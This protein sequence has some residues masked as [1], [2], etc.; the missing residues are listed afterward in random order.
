MT[1]LKLMV[2]GVLIFTAP[3][4]QPV[5]AA[6]VILNDAF[7]DPGN[8]LGINTNGIGDGFTVFIAGNTGPTGLSEGSEWSGSVFQRC[9]WRLPGKYRLQRL[10]TP[11]PQ[12]GPH[13]DSMERTALYQSTS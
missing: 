10:H 3:L 11:E 4:R 12:L 2:C 8:N 5:R 7:N 9:K 13:G 6:V 1:S